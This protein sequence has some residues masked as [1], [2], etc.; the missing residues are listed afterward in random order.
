MRNE[1]FQQSSLIDH[2]KLHEILGT[3][4]GPMREPFAGL[5]AAPL[6]SKRVLTSLVRLGDTLVAAGIGA[7]IWYLYLQPASY[8]ESAYYLTFLLGVG[9]VVPILFGGAGLYSI[10]AFLRPVEQV[11]RLTASWLAIFA[12]LFAILFPA[13]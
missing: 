13:H 10:H 9:L 3:S 8:I 12:A 11:A 5:D 7:I 4:A 2:N 1:P 6:I